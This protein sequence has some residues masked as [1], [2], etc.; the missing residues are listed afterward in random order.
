[1]LKY[2]TLGAKLLKCCYHQSGAS[3]LKWV[4]PPA[5]LLKSTS[6]DI[7]ALDTVGY[8]GASWDIGFFAKKVFT[9][10]AEQI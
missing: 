6:W 8:P 3:L 2:E 7:P 1:M 9:P 10:W 5:K 4:S